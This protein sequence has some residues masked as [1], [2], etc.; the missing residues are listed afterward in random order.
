MLA[1]GIDSRVEGQQPTSPH[2]QPGNAN[3][4]RA[5]HVP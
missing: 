2:V 5:L 1:I 4:G 3:G